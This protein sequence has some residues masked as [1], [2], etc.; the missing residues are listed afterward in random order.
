MS[1]VLRMLAEGGPELAAQLEE[2]ARSG[3]GESGAA[4]A[5]PASGEP[6]CASVDE[7]CKRLGL[8]CG[9]D[10][11]IDSGLLQDTASNGGELPTAQQAALGPA[12]ASGLFLALLEGDGAR[13]RAKR[14]SLTPSV[15]V[16]AT[17]RQ[18]GAV[19]DW[20]ELGS[21]VAFAGAEAV[22]RAAFG[23]AQTAH[24]VALALEAGGVYVFT[25]GLFGVGKADLLGVHRVMARWLSLVTSAA[26]ALRG[27]AG[28]R[29]LTRSEDYDL[30]LPGEADLL[31]SAPKGGGALA[32]GIR[33]A[34]LT[35]RER[36]AL[37]NTYTPQ[38]RLCAFMMEHEFPRRG[39]RVRGDS[40]YVHVKARPRVLVR[41]RVCL[42]CMR[43]R[44]RPGC[45]GS[46]NLSPRWHHVC[47]VCARPGSA[48]GRAARLRPGGGLRGGAG[49]PG[50]VRAAARR[51]RRPPAR[52]RAGGREP[53]R[54]RGP[55]PEDGGDGQPAHPRLRGEAA[56]GR[57]ARSLPRGG[58]R[59]PPHRQRDLRQAR[60]SSRA[61]PLLAPVPV[62]RRLRRGSGLR[63]GGALPGV[64][65]PHPGDLRRRRRL[66][67]GLPRVR[68]GPVSKP[69][70]VP[71]ARAGQPCRPRRRAR[72]AGEG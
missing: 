69:P 61:A 20:K 37:H 6:G 43:R 25:D 44:C 58:E 33:A 45:G 60:R 23:E 41:S 8:V 63:Q 5:V 46:P 3:P 13:F 47:A 14:A 31:P 71:H 38:Q 65:P 26:D 55:A 57:A 36:F 70:R 24:L 28:L 49:R 52:V 68:A 62:P 10:A 27:L 1:D 53:G 32:G 67:G 18:V 51:R 34:V 66:P 56:A 21:R 22:E 54:V 39:W 11:V 42:R 16:P 64:L 2:A 17:A 72:P 50:R 35:G 48:R 7:T 19:T 59:P 40:V 12:R 9:W 4:A 29:N 15:V 30:P